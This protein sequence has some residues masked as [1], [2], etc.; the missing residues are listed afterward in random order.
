LSSQAQKQTQPQAKA[1]MSETRAAIS[2]RKKLLGHVIVALLLLNVALLQFGQLVTASLVWGTTSK[3]ENSHD[4]DGVLPAYLP[5]PMRGVAI[6]LPVIPAEEEHQN[7]K[8]AVYGG[9]AERKHIGGFIKIDW[10]SISP[11]VW[12]SMI[13]YIGVKSL[14][15][16]GCGKGFSTSWFV[17]HGVDA[18]CVE[19][20]HDAV[21]NTLL[22]D[23]QTQ[24]VQHDFSRGPWWPA[25]TVDAI[26]CME[27][28]EHIGRNYQHNYLAAMKKA[29][30]IFVSHAEGGGGWH[31]VEVHDS[32]W[33]RVRM[34]SF[35]FVYS[36]ELT[37]KVIATGQAEAA[38]K[39]TRPDDKKQFVSAGYITGGAIQ[40]RSTSDAHFHVPPYIAQHSSHGC[41]ISSTY[42]RYLSTQLWLPYQNMLIS[43][44]NMD[45]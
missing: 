23:P 32:T 36:E 16:V 6:A 25:K 42:Y 10:N 38:Q 44:Q 43:W 35:G 17:M 41:Y 15:D 9:R 3:N 34:E 7:K 45:A 1:M 14:L 31:H 28:T 20:S 4:E 13:E 19:G 11:A 18:Q 12:K 21:L 22:P 30:F 33:W 2:S 27:V 5:I 26:W 8:P 24:L 29:A 37:K 39:V 40:V